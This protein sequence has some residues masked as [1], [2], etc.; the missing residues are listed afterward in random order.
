MGYLE[1]LLAGQRMRPEDE[2]ALRGVR[3]GL[4]TVL[5]GNWK[6]GDPRFYYAGS[7]GKRTMI[8]EAFDLDLVVYFPPT[9]RFTVKA[10]Y[11]AIE[12][13][14]HDNKYVTTRHNVAIR[15]PYQGGFYV[16]IVPGRAVSND[17]RYAKLYSSDSDSIKQ[18]SIKVHIDLARGN[19]DVIKILKVWRLRH[20]ISIRSFVLELA[21]TQA[22]LANRQPA[23]TDR[24][25]KVL[26]YL[27]DSFAQARLV[28]PANSTNLVSQE[29]PATTKQ[30][31]QAAARSSCSKSNWNEIVW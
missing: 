6:T 12:K 3:D 28:D 8:R 4:E 2:N 25:W 1:D 15:L 7:F 10:F 5:R 21:T 22:L 23:L 11:E 29:V 24:V 17:Y 20:G 26:V 31:I 30:M 13:R 14:L 9:E 18:T 27:R 19:Q 16:D